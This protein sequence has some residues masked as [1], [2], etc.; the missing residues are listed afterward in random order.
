MSFVST[1]KIIHETIVYVIVRV[2][3]KK[4]MAQNRTELN[5]V[6]RGRGLLTKQPGNHATTVT[7]PICMIGQQSLSKCA[8]Y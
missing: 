5:G 3:H 1:L 8:C 6:A 4:F 2:R 7:C